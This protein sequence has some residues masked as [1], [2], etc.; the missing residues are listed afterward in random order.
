DLLEDERHDRHADTDHEAFEA[1][2]PRPRRRP[3]VAHARKPRSRGVVWHASRAD[4]PCRAR[5]RATHGTTPP[6]G[7]NQPLTMPTAQTSS[8]NGRAPVRGVTA[9]TDRSVSADSVV[10]GAAAMA[11][12]YEAELVALQVIVP[13]SPAGTEAGAAEA[14]RASFAAADLET[15]ARELAG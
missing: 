7:H 5:R 14:T 10:R 2:P 15:F 11:N 13:D 8:P 6:P 9:A 12:R 1:P 4:A 3:C